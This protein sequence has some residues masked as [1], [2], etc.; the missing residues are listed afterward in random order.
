M[1]FP[2]PRAAAITA[3][4][5]AGLSLVLIAT[6]PLLWWGGV[7]F[8]P[9]MTSP[10]VGVEPLKLPVIA[11]FALSGAALV[12]LRP[13][14]PI[15][16]L[17]L[18]CGLLQAI[19]NSFAAYG[20]RALTDPDQSL[21]LGLFAAWV[22]S[23]TWLPAVLL[24]VLV[25][26]PLYPTG[27]LE[28][29]F[30]RWHVRVSLSGIAVLVL[31]AASTDFAIADTVK[32]A[33]MPFDTPAWW[34]V[35]TF[36]L[37]VA[38]VVPAAAVSFVG[39]VVRAIRA[40]SPERQQLVWLIGVVAAMLATVFLPSSEVFAIVY[41]LV[42]VAVVVGVVRYRLLGIEIVMRRTLLYVPLALL[43]ALVIGGVTTVLSRVTGDRPLALLIASAVVSLIVVPVAGRLRHWVDLFV[44][45]DRADP[46]AAVDHVGAGLAEATANPF[47]SMLETVA[48]S[49]GATYAAIRDEA[50]AGVARIGDTVRGSLE[51]PLRH[52]GEV[53]GSVVIGPRR[54]A[55]S[56][57][58]RDA[59]LLEALAPHLAVVV[60]SLRLTE[61]LAR[62]KQRVLTATSTERE[63]LRRDLHDG[64]GPSLS[65]IAL[66][67][68]AAE[69][70]LEHDLVTTRGL[71]TRTRVEAETALSEVRRV[72]NGLRPSALDR[73]NIGD[74]IRE[75]AVSLGMN[76]SGGPACTIDVQGAE[77]L[78]PPVE[79]AA[80]RIVAESLT[81]VARHA[82]ARTCHVH[83]CRSN[84]S[85]LLS[86]QD[87]GRGLAPDDDPGVGL[88]SIRLRA[89]AVR[90]RVEIKGS[91]THGTRISA[92]LPLGA[93]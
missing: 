79:E 18:G 51:L 66:G 62:Q 84:G 30:W 67:L 3:W 4:V 56:V 12:H 27:K 25:L 78:P 47:V 88:E 33:R 39:T 31:G 68:E 75:T 15:G 19:Q 87:D 38:L 2:S 26:P 69:R 89:S 72:L 36:G 63:R 91:T 50:G 45:G 14:N 65:G 76:R 9:G 24:P 52:R 77:T 22:G 29:A 7:E 21:P 90:G 73:H 86:V 11:G 74:A 82:H 55:R 5:L 20:A 49:T 40:R 60:G 37:A 32:A 34:S 48:T 44:L 59:R 80:F 41:G 42:P 13:G 71:L 61:E 8:R 16:W 70:A 54:G 92:A 85:L 81:N 57:D 43:V 46:L 17:L 6:I 64:L 83:M 23:W 53:L 28:S 1:P 58:A 35:G 93:P 10:G